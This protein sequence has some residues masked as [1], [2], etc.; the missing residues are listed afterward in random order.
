MLNS[1]PHGDFALATF[2]TDMAS[3]AAWL[4]SPLLRNP[5]ILLPS[6]TTRAFSCS[7]TTS[8]GVRHGSRLEEPL[9]YI[10]LNSKSHQ[11]NIIG[12]NATEDEVY[13]GDNDDDVDNKD[14]DYVNTE[15]MLFRK[16]KKPFFTYVI[17]KPE[18]LDTKSSSP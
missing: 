14:E 11:Y 15:T 12:N 6:P 1:L 4:I 10:W 5:S 9:T 17:F 7:P 8:A 16:K 2:S 3:C 13:F 18:E